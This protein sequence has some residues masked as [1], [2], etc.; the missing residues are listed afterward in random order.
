M[1]NGK[2]D[3]GGGDFYK[4]NTQLLSGYS[5]N[6]T[7]IFMHD[8][9]LNIDDANYVIYG[10][11]ARAIRMIDGKL[12][13]NGASCIVHGDHSYAVYSSIPGQN[14]NLTDI[15]FTMH[16][17]TE[18]GRIVGIYSTRSESGESG[19][20]SVH[21]SEGEESYINIEAP[22][23]VAIYT[24]G[25]DVY[26]QGCDYEITGNNSSG[27]YSDEGKV[28]IYDGKIQL[29]SNINCYGIYA[30]SK[31]E[32]VAV[33]IN[34][35][36]A[37]IDVGYVDS[38]TPPT[39]VHS[40]CKAC[41]GVFL[42]SA[43]PDSSVT[44]NNSNVHCYEVGV[45]LS[46]GNLLIKDSD[47]TPNT[48]K[49]NRASAVAVSGGD[50]VFEAGGTYN[51]TSYNTTKESPTNSYE[52][53][54]PYMDYNNGEY[55]IDHVNYRNTDGVYVNGGSLEMRGMANIT[56]TGLDNG[57]KLYNGK[58]IYNSL[59]VNSYAIRVTGGSVT[60][61]KANISALAGG[62]IY[63]SGGDM[64]M[65]NEDTVMS[66]ITLTAS[67]NDKGDTYDS[68]GTLISTG[69][70]SKVNINGGHAIEL[71]GGNITIYNGTYTATFGNGVAANGSG[72]ITIHNGKFEGW[73]IGLSDKSGP[74]AYYGLKVIGGA[75]VYIYD[76]E[77][78]GG[79]GGA[80]VT[81]IDQ[82]V[83]TT[84]LR[85]TTG[86]NATV[87]VYRGIFGDKN[88]WDGFNLYDMSTVIFG[89]GAEG[90]YSSASQY[91]NA[92]KVYG[93]STAVATNRLTNGN[94]YV[95]SQLYV[96]Y[97]TYDGGSGHGSCYDNG[98][99][100]LY[101]YNQG[102]NY[103]IASGS[104]FSKINTSSPIYYPQVVLP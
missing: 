10:D 48:I 75:T 24:S 5:H 59:I 63:C 51:L 80:F 46:G 18:I 22:G 30:I 90:T 41:I 67:G 54:V 20:V 69:W 33:H 4:V 93:N 102:H 26:S 11:Y 21:T 49:T 70:Q 8:G 6:D 60:V 17:R 101:F 3:I 96:Y 1:Q 53:T 77:F 66:D 94:Y 13:I 61:L 88:H 37:T 91:A 74:A 99:A 34:V 56:H 89:A 73:M 58:H 32:D 45:A 79:N 31:S 62:G 97:G 40:D 85:S 23:S 19:T 36:H 29:N 57:E 78:Y 27:I 25:G 12:D 15:K 42:G 64:T 104:N 9:E 7:A 72:T 65:G 87:Y 52:M 95:A 68:I 103:T 81:G 14:L 92:I 47:D 50:L 44:L 2:L 86:K 76:G 55:T 84:D 43:N 100:T 98:M 16:A 39:T 38:D 83:S 71:N 35:N 82:F 28:E